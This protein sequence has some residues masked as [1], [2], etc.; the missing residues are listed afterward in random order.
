MRRVK[1][2][3]FEFVSQLFQ[4]FLK[5]FIEAFLKMPTRP[6]TIFCNFKILNEHVFTQIINKKMI[7]F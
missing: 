1:N 3:S 6:L 7:L 4:N 2:H 5:Q